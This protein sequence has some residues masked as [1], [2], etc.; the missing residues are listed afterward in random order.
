MK[1]YDIETIISRNGEVTHVAL[2]YG[3]TLRRA[4]CA[5]ASYD[6]LE[7]RIN[8]PHARGAGWDWWSASYSE[9]EAVVRLVEGGSTI[10]EA[11]KQV[12]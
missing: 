12:L 3:R 10:R 1:Y 5:I 4:N 6:G 9:W 8:V 2:R 11:V 7:E